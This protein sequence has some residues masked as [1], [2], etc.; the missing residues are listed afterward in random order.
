MVQEATN[1][2]HSIEGEEDATNVKHEIPEEVVG[3]DSAS[4]LS[5]LR[6]DKKEAEDAENEGEELEVEGTAKQRHHPGFHQ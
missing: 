1:A 4:E 3:A 5:S 2:E 6:D